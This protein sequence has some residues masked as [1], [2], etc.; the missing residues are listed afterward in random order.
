MSLELEGATEE[1]AEWVVVDWLC[2]DFQNFN[3]VSEVT[4]AVHTIGEFDFP[5]D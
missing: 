3:N 5:Y 2:G 4:V 1:G